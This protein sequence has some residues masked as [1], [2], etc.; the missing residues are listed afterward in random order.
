MFLKQPIYRLIYHAQRD[1]LSREKY[2]WT[3]SN[4]NILQ[5]ID[6]ICS[7]KIDSFMDNLAIGAKS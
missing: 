3:S 7:L 1:Y 4:I 5:V 2:F 6:S